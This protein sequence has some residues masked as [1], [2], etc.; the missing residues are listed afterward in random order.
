MGEGDNNKSMTYLASECCGQLRLQ[1]I[2]N[3]WEIMPLSCSTEGVRKLCC[4]STN[5]HPP[6]D[7]DK[8]FRGEEDGLLFTNSY[9]PLAEGCSQGH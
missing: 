9:P 2:R 7:E 8:S 1:T 3:L 5:P 4:L 6:L